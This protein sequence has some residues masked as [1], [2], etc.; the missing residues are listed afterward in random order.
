[1][2]SDDLNINR[3]GSDYLSEFEYVNSIKVNIL[4]ALLFNLWNIDPTKLVLCLG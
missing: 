1:M 4:I 3:L 2:G